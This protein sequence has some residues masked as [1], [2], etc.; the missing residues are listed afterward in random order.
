MSKSATNRITSNDVYQEITDRVCE[1]LESGVAPWRKPWVGGGTSAMPVSF[2]TSKPYRGVNVLLL[3]MTQMVRGY[4]S[5]YWLTY[6]QAQAKGGQVRKG[7]KGT[8]VVFWNFFKKD[9]KGADGK[10]QVDENGN[11]QQDTIPFMKWYTVFNTNQIDGLDV[12]NESTEPLPVD[13]AE[14]VEAGEAVLAGWAGKPD[15]GFGGGKAFY[16]PSTD[17]IQMPERETFNST[18]GYYSTLFHEMVHSTGH[19]SRLD[20][21]EVSSPTFFGSHNYS[22]EELVAELGSCFIAASTGV[23]M[24]LD[25]SAAYCAGWL[26]VL[27]NDNRFVLSAASKAQKAADMIL[28]TEE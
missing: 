7:E 9:A 28:G 18:A 8:R 17:T 16:R 10:P 11:V 12:P 2:I 26:K 3:A 13:G 15:I 24:D 21:P 19:K 25:N 5:R 27:K 22:K 6:K 23:P 14:I 1:M 20:R 4:T